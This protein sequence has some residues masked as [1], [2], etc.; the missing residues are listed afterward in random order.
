MHHKA[1]LSV[2]DSMKPY[3]VKC[4]CS[5]SG[6]FETELQARNW[7]E[8]QH[9]A[10]LTGIDVYELVSTIPVAQ[11]PEPQP[12]PDPVVIE[13]EPEPEPVPVPA[14]APDPEPPS[15]EP[16]L[17]AKAAGGVRNFF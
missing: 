16:P 8:Y 6:E 13:P 11:E 1:I 12:A 10:G 4:S 3:R 2:T 5:T 7:I 9:F 17:Q 15:A 14:P